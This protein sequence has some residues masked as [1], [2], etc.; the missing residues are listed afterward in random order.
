MSIDFKLICVKLTYMFKETTKEEFKKFFEPI[1][2]KLSIK[3]RLM[4]DIELPISGFDMTSCLSNNLTDFG[5]S[6]QMDQLGQVVL[7]TGNLEIDSFVTG[8]KIKLK[9][10]LGVVAAQ[11]NGRIV[12][13]TDYGFFGWLYPDEYNAITH[14]TF[15]NS[16]H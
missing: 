12:M 1:I 9:N 5:I 14:N 13:L 2:K 6:N 15:S 8:Q 11:A 3:D 16:T 4:T 10:T 7:Y